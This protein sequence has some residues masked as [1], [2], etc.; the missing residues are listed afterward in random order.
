MKYILFLNFF[1]AIVTVKVD[2]QNSGL[3]NATNFNFFSIEVDR[4]NFVN[5]T[6]WYFIDNKKVYG[7]PFLYD[8]WYQGTILMADSV[9]YSQYKVKYNC[10]TQELSFSDGKDSLIVDKEVAG[11]SINVA[12]DS[13]VFNFVNG[14]QY[15]E[16]KGNKYYEVLANNA[17]GAY[18]RFNT[19]EMVSNSTTI[20]TSQS[21]QKFQY[22]FDY[23]YYNKITKKF[24][25][26]KDDNGNWLALIN[27]AVYAEKPE[28]I[29]KSKA[30]TNVNMVIDF[31]EEYKNFKNG[32]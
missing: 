21:D 25:K 22:K 14:K 9:E 1:L 6:T 3:N 11:F 28:I 16:K 31:L 12:D 18:V 13:K 19:K 23:K 26:V 24:I 5:S 30:L 32:K 20:A 27:D 10:F 7:S 15:G 4:R 17:Y 29:V 2:A 8:V